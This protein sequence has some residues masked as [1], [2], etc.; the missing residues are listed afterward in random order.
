[1]W[2]GRL[3]QQP[4]RRPPRVGGEGSIN[5]DDPAGCVNASRPA[6]WPRQLGLLAARKRGSTASDNGTVPLTKIGSS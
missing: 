6:A 3:R 5:F 1:M 4:A 2:Q